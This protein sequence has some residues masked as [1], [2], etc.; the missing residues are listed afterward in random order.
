[1]NYFIIYLIEMLPT[2]LDYYLF[3]FS[4]IEI[5]T[6]NASKEFLIHFIEHISKHNKKFI[7]FYFADRLL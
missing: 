6:A 3:P 7:D 4:L 1:M 5:K 2:I